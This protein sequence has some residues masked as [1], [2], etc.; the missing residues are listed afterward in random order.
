MRVLVTGGAGF[1]GHHVVRALVARGDRVDVIDANVHGNPRTVPGALYA[2]QPLTKSTIWE[3]RPD[4]VVH[5]AAVGGASIAARHPDYTLKMNVAATSRLLRQL[6]DGCDPRT[7]VLASSFSVYGDFADGAT[8][9]GQL[10]PLELYAATKAMQ[11][12]AMRAS[13][14]PYTILRFSSVYGSGMRVDDAEATIV[15]KLAGWIGRG[16]RPKLF[17]DG[18]QTRDFVFVDDVVA[19]ILK[20][21]DEPGGVYNVCSGKGTSLLDACQHIA[22]AMGTTVEPVIT[23]TKRPGDM[24]HCEGR[25][26]KVTRFLGRRPV[27][28]EE[29]ACAAFSSP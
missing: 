21:I 12:L 4:A 24:R 6:R 27:R 2:F 23:G 18:R 14:C 17:E 28:F 20:A 29:G 7:I 3:F 25:A 10:R 11:E 8:E 1:I 16:E 22:M 15:A 9:E 26:E 5:L 13:P 19:C